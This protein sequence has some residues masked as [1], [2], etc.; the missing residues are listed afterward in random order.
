MTPGAAFILGTLFGFV[1]ML[2]LAAVN[3]QFPAGI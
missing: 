2:V 1:S 3:S